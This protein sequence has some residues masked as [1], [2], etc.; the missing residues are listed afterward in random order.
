[1]SGETSLS[2]AAAGWLERLGELND[3]PVELEPSSC[4]LLVVDMQRY[5]VDCADGEPV[6]ELYFGADAA[7]NVRRLIGAF[8]E[9]GN[10][11]VYTRHAHDDLSFEGGAGMMSVWWDDGIEEGTPESEIVAFVEPRG[12]EVLTKERYSAFFGT[13][14]EGYLRRNGISQVAICGVMTNLCCETTARDA[15]MR[16]FAVFFAADATATKTEQMHVASLMNLAYGF[17]KIVTADE[18][19]G[20]LK[21]PGGA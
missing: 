12:E 8:R 16:D 19:I 1:M 14:L 5:F 17:A 21:A 9:S 3:H 4:A 10:L 13:E 2:E 18:I 7:R 15:F 6:S 11:I 20:A